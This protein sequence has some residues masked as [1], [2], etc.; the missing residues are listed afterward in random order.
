IKQYAT[1]KVIFGVCLG[2]QAIGEAFGAE[3]YNLSEV[4]HGIEHEMQRTDAES[5]ILKDIPQKFRAGR[6]HSWSIKPDSLPAEFIVTAQEETG[7]I[8]AMR[9]R[10]H[11]V[12]G[13]QFHPESI[14]TAEGRKM[15][16][17]LLNYTKMRMGGKV[18]IGETS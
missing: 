2:H 8:M 11:A 6:Y 9:H 10:D 15:I 7:A 18:E 5:V 16:A 14:M 3:I 12:F 1:E 13:V 4:F 17:N